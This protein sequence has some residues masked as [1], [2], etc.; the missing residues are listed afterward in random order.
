MS[1]ARQLWSNNQDLARAALA[2]R[3]VRAIGRGSGP[4]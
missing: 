1:L 4:H 2:H 3:F